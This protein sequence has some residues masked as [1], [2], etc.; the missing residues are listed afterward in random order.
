MLV[1][2]F[3]IIVVDGIDDPEE[4]VNRKG[5]LEIKVEESRFLMVDTRYYSYINLFLMG[6]SESEYE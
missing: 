4:V 3:T 6:Y 1:I 2:F 5:E